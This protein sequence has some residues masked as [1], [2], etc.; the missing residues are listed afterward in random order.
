MPRIPLRATLLVWGLIFDFAA[1]SLPTRAQPQSQAS[2]RGQAPTQAPAQTKKPST[3]PI[4]PAAP[5]STHY[6]VLLLAV[7][8]NPSWNLRIGPKGPERLDR[9]DYPPMVLEPAEVTHE[10]TGEAWAYHAKDAATSAAVVVHLSREACSDATTT[11][12]S[13]KAVVEHTQLGTLNGCARIAAE[14][15]P[16]LN[17]NPD[18]DDDVD[19]KKPPAETT[20]VTNFKLPVD[21]AYISPT[22]KIVLKHGKIPHIV[23]QQGSQLNLSHDGKR[24]LYTRGEGSAR[25]IALYDSATSKTTDLFTGDVQQAFWSPDDTRIAFMKMTDTHWHLWIAPATSPESAA[26]SA[27][28]NDIV[29]IQGWA[30]SHTILVDDLQQLSWIGDDGAVRQAVP[31]KDIYG[32]FFLGSSASTFRLHPLNPDLLLVSAEVLKSAVTSAPG[33]K[34]APALGFFLY[35]I[36]AHRRVNMSPPDML[37]QNA[38]W[39]RDGFQIFFTGTD[40]ARRIATWHIFWD[41]ALLKRYSDGTNLVIGQ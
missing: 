16:R 17:Q 21:V 8:A 9:P 36:Q 4:G 6:P 3:T 15:F 39:S 5:Q 10:P 31:D 38:E 29:S 14:L 33:S 28:A 34:P 19:A 35:E 12:Y 37:S 27:Y 23:A 32:D 22:K 11:K 20:T 13:F 40:S 25:S 30:D 1:A 18:D 41:G 7:G 26:Q 24:L 2:A